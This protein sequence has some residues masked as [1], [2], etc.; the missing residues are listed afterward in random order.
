MPPWEPGKRAVPLVGGCRGSIESVPD[1]ILEHI[2][3]FLLSPEAVRTSMLAW[4][5]RHLWRSTTG[6]RVGCR[7]G[8]AVDPMSVEELRSLV[9]HLFVGSPIQRCELTFRSFTGREDVPHVNL[10]FREVVM[11]KARVLG[12]RLFGNFLYDT[13]LER[14]NITLVSKHLARLELVGV[15]VHSSLINFSSCPV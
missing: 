4:R 7:R 1:G 5:W 6:L 2:L 12:L 9:N 3:G 8:R 11:C 15:R 14:D 10:W 13:W